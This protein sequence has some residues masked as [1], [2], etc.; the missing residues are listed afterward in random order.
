M[1]NFREVIDFGGFSGS[2]TPQVGNYPWHPPPPYCRLPI[3]APPKKMVLAWTIFHIFCHFPR[4]AGP[5]T[6]CLSRTKPVQHQNKP[7]E[8][9]KPST[10]ELP[11]SRANSVSSPCH[12]HLGAERLNQFGDKKVG[13]FKNPRYQTCVGSF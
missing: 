13:C 10:S 3:T 1:L 9:Q 7:R 2:I 8:S 11:C 12:T 6:P 5:E 4:G